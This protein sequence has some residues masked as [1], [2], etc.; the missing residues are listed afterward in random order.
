MRFEHN[1]GQADSSISFLGRGLAYSAAFYSDRVS[2][3]LPLIGSTGKSGDCAK[4]TSPSLLSII[5]IGGRTHIEPVGE[6]ALLARTN[7]FRGTDQSAWQAGTKSYHRVVY[8]QVWPGIDLVYYGNEGALEFDFQLRPNQSISPIRFRIDGAH[9]VQADPS[10]DLVI[11][12]DECGENIRLLRPFVYQ[13]FNGSRH[14]VKARYTVNMAGEIGFIVER[15]DETRRLIID[16]ILEFASYLGGNRIDQAFGIAVDQEGNT[17]VTGRT[18]SPDFFVKVDAFQTTY[19]GVSFDAFVTKIGQNGSTIIYSAY[20]G[21]SALDEGTAITVDEEGFAIVVGRTTSSDFPLANAVQ[22]E[23]GGFADSVGGGIPDGDGFVV[24]INPDGSELQFASYIGGS[25]SD[26]ANGVALTADGNIVVAGAT[27]SSDF[28][29]TDAFQS[30]SNGKRDGF[31]AILDPSAGQIVAA[32]YLGGEEDDSIYDVATSQ[33]GV[34]FVAGETTSTDFPT[35]TPL[36]PVLAGHFDAF[37]AAFTA[38]AGSLYY[39]TYLGGSGDDVGRSVVHDPLGSTYIAGDTFSNDFPVINAIQSDLQGLQDAFIAKVNIDASAWNYVTYLGGDKYEVAYDIA[40]DSTGN[41]YVAGQ[42]HSEDFPTVQAFQAMNRGQSDAFVSVFNPQGDDFVYSSYLGGGD[43]EVAHGISATASGRAHVAGNTFSSNL[44]VVEAFQPVPGN[45]GEAFL[46]ILGPESPSLNIE[47]VRPERIGGNGQVTLT[48]FGQ[49]IPQDTAIAIER[50]GQPRI[51]GEEALVN[52]GGTEVRSVFRVSNLAHGP[53]DVVV[54]LPDASEIRLPGG[55]LVEATKAPT[56]E[57]DLVGRTRVR[58]FQS[59]P[60]FFLYT[61]TGNVDAL[62]VPIWLAGFPP[63]AIIDFHFD[64][65][66]PTLPDEL[67]AYREVVEQS[68]IV[69]RDGGKEIGLFLPR[70]PPGYQG[71]LAMSVIYPAPRGSGEG[72]AIDLDILHTITAQPASPLYG[73][74]GSH[75]DW[76]AAA[77]LLR[78]RI[79]PCTLTAGQAALQWLGVVSPGAN[80]IES[81]VTSSSL[82]TLIRLSKSGVAEEHLVGSTTG[83]VAGMLV[84]CLGAL[85]PQAKLLAAFNAIM[86]TLEAVDECFGSGVLGRGGLSGLVASLLVHVVGAVDPNEKVGNLGADGFLN[87]KG[88]MQYTIFFENLPAAT[89]PA[90][91]VR[92]LDQLPVENLVLETLTIGAINFGDKTIFPDTT[93]FPWTTEV[94]LRPEQPLIVHI[95][96]ELDQESGTL[97]WRFLALDA[98]TGMPSDDPDLGFLP[99]NKVPPDGEGSVSFSVMPLPEIESGAVLRNTASIIF[100]MNEPIET[101]VWENTIDKDAPTSWIVALPEE[102]EGESFEVEW[103][104]E[105]N[106]AGIADYTVYVAEDEQDFNVWLESTEAESALFEGRVNVTYHFKVE[107]RDRV[108]NKQ[109]APSAVV[110]TTTI[111]MKAKNHGCGCNTG[112]DPLRS[113]SLW[114]LLVLKL[115][116]TR[117]RRSASV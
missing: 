50:E 45:L 44:V 25:N 32:T 13:E 60:I 71:S 22:E 90:Q 114:A 101:N 11:Q 81:A 106:G 78:T 91:E 30:V 35:Q 15:Y 84:G 93:R 100:D 42:T 99:P 48:V 97:A 92:I 57:V 113:A 46:A 87:G 73:L 20:L 59:Q 112:Q 77:N 67:E 102:I 65:T 14:P 18:S 117:K 51:E 108:G 72:A 53:W 12:A 109:T 89:A 36:Q 34:I 28:P 79:L 56:V 75:D 61:N 115:F 47:R 33:T 10:G 110:A 7:Y 58:F 83:L 24:R 116:L 26:G 82:S 37:I 41:L 107:A 19:D 8:P 9:S 52:Q 74:V 55:V 69:E 54:S 98:A 95:T 68:P 4:R 49:Q 103:T 38:D 29:G 80:C 39:S 66:P 21:G 76:L 17:Y 23:Y 3:A 85:T 96:A 64:I 86:G 88:P 62:A 63:D 16:P 27:T 111:P 31:V 2:I 43:H 105:D 40:L 94:D 6:E 5:P 1:Q 70:V 104:G